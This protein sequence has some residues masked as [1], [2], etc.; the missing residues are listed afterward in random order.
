MDD[1]RK[2]TW[3]GVLLALLFVATLLGGLLVLRLTG[4]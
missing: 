4:H 3:A 1:H 2:D